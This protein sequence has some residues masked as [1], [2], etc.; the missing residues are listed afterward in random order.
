MVEIN[1]NDMVTVT[2]TAKGAAI[3]E[4]ERRRRNVDRRKRGKAVVKRKFV[5]GDKVRGQLHNI[6]H[7]FA[8]YM[9][10]GF[11]IPFLPSVQVEH[12]ELPPSWAISG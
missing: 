7:L 3:K 5:E 10:L 12:E 2:L 4:A 6:I 8:P 11:N 9:G 1:L